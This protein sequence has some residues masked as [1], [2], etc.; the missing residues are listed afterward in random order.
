[1]FLLKDSLTDVLK[2]YFKYLYK[3][4]VNGGLMVVYGFSFSIIPYAVFLLVGWYISAYIWFLVSLPIT[5][6]FLVYYFTDYKE[7][8]PKKVNEKYDKKDR[9]TINYV[10][11]V[12]KNSTSIYE[13]RDEL[14]KW[15]KL[16]GWNYYN[17]TIYSSNHEN[18]I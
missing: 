12:S 4:M 6:S 9:I 14:E 15:L 16:N 17:G 13:F 11:D 7:N 2:E 5:V 10:I 8:K 18:S 1:V 3:I